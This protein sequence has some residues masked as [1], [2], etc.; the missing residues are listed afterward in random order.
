MMSLFLE[1]LIM[2]RI[3]AFQNG[4]GVSKVP[5]L[6][7]GRAYYWKDNCVCDLG[8]LISGGLIFGRSFY[9]NCTV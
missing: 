7:F 2:E 8:D 1:G 9:R 3:L 4:L 6:I 5:G